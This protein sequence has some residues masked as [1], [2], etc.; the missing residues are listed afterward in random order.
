MGYIRTPEE[1]KIAACWLR[2]EVI[3]LMLVPV[4]LVLSYNVAVMVRAVSAAY[5]SALFRRVDRGDRLLGL[6]RNLLVLTCILGISFLVGFVPAS[7][8]SLSQQYIFVI[9][10]SFSGVYILLTN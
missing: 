8:E 7:S 6:T 1:G 3:S 10:N 9:L 4:A 2:S 5:Q